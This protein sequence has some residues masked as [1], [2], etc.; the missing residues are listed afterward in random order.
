VNGWTINY[1]GPRFGDDYLLRSAVAK[2]QIYVTVPEEALYPVA[3]VD[4]DGEPLDGAHA[5]RIVFPPGGR[6]PADAFWSLTMY[7]KDEFLFPNSI[8]R[9]AIGDRTPRLHKNPD[10]SLDIVIQHSAP[11]RLRS[12]WLPCPKG[13][14]FVLLRLYQ[15]KPSVVKGT[16]LLPTITRVG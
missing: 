13:G 15:P 7:G 1:A 14:F 10:G 2:D 5:Y 11:R 12:N 9:Y 4:A 8:R 6:P 3:A 16:W